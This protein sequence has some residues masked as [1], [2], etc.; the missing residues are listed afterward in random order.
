MLTKTKQFP[1][2]RT[3]VTRNAD[4]TYVDVDY[5]NNPL[6][7]VALPHR[8]VCVRGKILSVP[9]Y[10]VRNGDHNWVVKIPKRHFPAVYFRDDRYLD[11]P[12]ES[13]AR[14]SQFL[15]A[16]YHTSAADLPD[17]DYKESCIKN[18]EFGVAGISACWRQRV[19][20]Q[21]TLQLVL[22]VFGDRQRSISF[23]AAELN[24][25][26]LEA[27]LGKLVYMKYIIDENASF[28]TKELDHVWEQI[29]AG[30]VSPTEP[31]PVSKLTM[32]QVGDSLTERKKVWAKKGTI[33]PYND[34]FVR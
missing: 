33:N 5:R 24:Q 12:E 26:R 6:V 4:V 2:V 30:V 31:H 3:P 1:H 8:D 23:K 29:L 21:Y 18:V 32:C 16:H 13:L 19:K 27:E 25:P 34:K 28:S 22:K 9:Q 15:R 7:S 10:I 17:R 11:L 20:G 14:A